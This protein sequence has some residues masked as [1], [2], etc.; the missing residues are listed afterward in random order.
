MNLFELSNDKDLFKKLF[1]DSADAILIIKDNKFID[2]NKAALQIF[3]VSSKEQLSNTYPSEISPIYQSNKRLSKD[4][5]QDMIDIALKNGSNRFE[6]VHKRANGELFFAEVLL[7][8]I[9]Y[10]EKELLHCVVRDIS[11]KKEAEKA[12]RSSEENYKFL[13]E[14][15]GDGILVGN[16]KGIIINT[17]ESI[18]KI[19]GY[20]V[21]ELIGNSISILFPDDV[22]KQKPLRFD[23][24]EAGQ[25]VLSDR[26][27]QKRDGSII[28]IEMN[29]TKMQNGNLQAF[30]R[31]ITE[32]KNNQ[33]KIIDKNLALQI[34][35]NKLKE[36][37]IKL[38]RINDKLKHQQKELEQAKIKAEESDRLKSA[39]LANM[40]HE[41]R[42]PMNGILGF[43]ELLKIPD[44]T[45][46]TQ[47]KYL[48]IIEL[49][50]KRMLNILNNLI[51]ISKIEAGQME[52][53]HETTNV[54]ELLESLYDFF[55]LE[56]NNKNIS[57]KYNLFCNDKIISINTDKGKLNQVITN[58]VKNAIKF[59]S[60][61][62]IELG[63][64][65]E[66]EFL[67]FYVKDDGI[68]IDSGFN[69]AVFHRF[70]Q[71]DNKKTEL[72]DGAGLGLSI[73]KA[74]VEMLGGK[75][76]F[77]SEINKGS[78]F[79]FTIPNVDRL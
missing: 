52:M 56:A 30:V 26:K 15:A 72:N 17:N 55:T 8:K 79:F 64:I 45:E 24:L 34:A 20:E 33:Q 12:L 11:Y 22:L 9:N 16:E 67:K 25:T 27:L 40:S 44:L 59:T 7:T 75:I 41:I 57:L 21:Q 5:A 43:T 47:G 54:N 31:D 74:F 78:T 6:W 23:L 63:C 76:W 19:T 38:L 65:V 77:E 13:F 71:A 18:S 2:C 14:Q 1:E 28:F 68:G 70:K 58:L 60:K 62:E 37:N 53:Y 66:N 3:L 61:G 48:D 4:K 35:E 32:W 50:G 46:D 36:T 49:S 51:D 29:S 73:S 69:E 39:F 42:T 10:R